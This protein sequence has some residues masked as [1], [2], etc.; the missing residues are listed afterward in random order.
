MPEGP[1]FSW[2]R[3]Q[4]VVSVATVVALLLLYIPEFAHALNV[5]TTDE[6]F[7]FA[8]FVP[9]LALGLLWTRR[10]A[11]VRALGPGSWL[12]LPLLLSGLVVLLLGARSGVNFIADDSFVLTTL[13]LVAYL[14]GL[15][16]MRVIAFPVLFLL[17]GLSL[18]RGLLSSVGFALQGLTA[19][20]SAAS[21]SLLG[22]PVY[23]NGVDLFAGV[24]A[25]QYH[26]I[27]AEQCSGMSSLLA[28]LC[29]GTLLVG[30]A[31]TML[32]RR[33]FL[34]ALIVPIVLAANVLRV[35]IVL[36]GSQV[37]GYGVTQGT[38]HGA[39][40]ASVFLTAFAL[41]YVV[42]RMMGCYRW[43]LPITPRATGTTA[44]S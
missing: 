35:T 16:A 18:F 30:I 38:L 9:P 34:I 20:A 23:R 24:G 8:F 27:V 26:F 37:I 17:F 7:S 41:H 33:V 10:Q 5:W 40:S 44:S 3:G 4:I 42:G 12:G 32:A 43:S 14:Y 21:A 36:T 2:T 39:L 19:Q 31:H 1:A 22:V 28:S 11:L 6:E 15:A 13:G 25:K 29:L